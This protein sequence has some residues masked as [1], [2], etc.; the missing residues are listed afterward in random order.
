[1][2]ADGKLRL[3]HCPDSVTDEMLGSAVRG[4]RLRPRPPWAESELRLPA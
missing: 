1:M 2:R 3:K 4:S